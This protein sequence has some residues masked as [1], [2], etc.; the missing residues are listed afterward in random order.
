MAACLRL[1]ECSSM[2]H[3]LFACTKRAGRVELLDLRGGAGRFESEWRRR[4]CRDARDTTMSSS[5]IDLGRNGG[6]PTMARR[7]AA[8]SPSPIK[9]TS[10]TRCWRANIRS[11]PETA[12]LSSWRIST[13]SLR[14]VPHRRSAS[15]K[16]LRLAMCAMALTAS[17]CALH[18]AINTPVRFNT[19]R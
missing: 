4:L 6:P 15:N 19:M 5:A 8:H 16:F 2:S 12:R 7:A 10:P 9:L 13:V 3:V 1:G 11:A 18:R 14:V 17:V